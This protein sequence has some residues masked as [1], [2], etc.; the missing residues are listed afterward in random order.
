MIMPLPR[1]SGHDDLQVV[2]SVSTGL[3]RLTFA[4]SDAPFRTSRLVIITRKRVER[5][6][7]AGALPR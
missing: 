6:A 7:L 2:R 3:F 4:G 5:M 1:Y